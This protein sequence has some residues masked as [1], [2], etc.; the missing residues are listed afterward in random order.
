MLN[1]KYLAVVLAVVAVVVAVYQVF[2]NKPAKPARQVNPA[3]VRPRPAVSPSPVQNTDP[4]K[5][6]DL[7]IDFA[8][9]ILLKR[10]YENPMGKFPRRELPDQFGRAI[11]SPP[12]HREDEPPTDTVTGS[13]VKKTEK[14]VKIKIAELERCLRQ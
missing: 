3:A 2:F 14:P 11:F 9:P 12:P 10:V 5:D 13:P 7:I 1:N 6:G 4:G 8:S